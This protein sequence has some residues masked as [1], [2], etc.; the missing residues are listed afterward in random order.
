M[1]PPIMAPVFFVRLSSATG[2]ASAG[3]VLEVVAS[4]DVAV[5]VFDV[6]DSDDEAVVSDEEVLEDVARL[7][8]V[9]L[10]LVEEEVALEL[11][12]EEVS[13]LVVSRVEVDS[14]DVTV[15]MVVGSDNVVG[16]AVKA[17]DR[18]TISSADCPGA[19]AATLV[20]RFDAPQPY[21]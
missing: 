13:S 18:L 5:S 14:L 8:E 9:A 6:S 11:V 4:V 12:E 3:A 10:E 17:T 7:V 2:A 15:Q 19:V 20:A 1:V 21:W 16:L